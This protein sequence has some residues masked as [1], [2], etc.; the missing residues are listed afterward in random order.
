MEILHLYTESAPLT[1][2]HLVANAN[3]KRREIVW[4]RG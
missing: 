2:L 4:E 3:V 1:A